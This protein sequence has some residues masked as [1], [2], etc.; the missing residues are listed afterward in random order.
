MDW[1]GL[2]LTSSGRLGQRD[3]WLAWLMLFAANLVCRIVPFLGG[4]VALA[5]V[6]PNVCVTSKR[7][8]DFGRSGWL[9]LIP[10]AAGLV[11]AVLGALT[12]GATMLAG[13]AG[14]A[15]GSLAMVGGMGLMALLGLALLVVALGFLLWVGLSRGDP[16]PNAYGPPPPPA[17]GRGATPTAV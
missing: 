11:A 17:F 1:K 5:L 7:L 4:L 8:H 6:F 2:F 15:V 3:F 16:E 12:R 10:F 13:L 14:H 9:I